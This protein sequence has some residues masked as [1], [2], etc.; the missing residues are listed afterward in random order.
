MT[1]TERYYPV[2]TPVPF[3]LGYLNESPVTALIFGHPGGINDV[4]H[5]VVDILGAVHRC[6]DWH[7]AIRTT[8]NSAR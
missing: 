6:H 3:E 1:R 5:L 4:N 8:E 2:V 7:R